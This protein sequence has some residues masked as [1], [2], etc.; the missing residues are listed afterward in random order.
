MDEVYCDIK[1]EINSNCQESKIF[2]EQ[3][4]RK[5]HQYLDSDILKELPDQFHQRFW[6][7]YLAASLLEAGLNLQRSSGRDGSD[8]CIKANDGSKIWVEAVTASLGQG[9][10]AVQETEIGAVRSVPDDQIKLRLLNAFAEK[11]R[12]YRCYR[13]KNWVGSEEP[14]IIAINAAQVPSATRELE[15][16]RIVRSLLP[17]GFQVLHLSRETLEVA[18]TSYEYQGEVV[19]ASGTEI[20]TTSFLNP[21]YSGISAV[22]YSC[23]DVFN[24]P[25]EISKALLLFHNPLSATP[26]PLAFLKNSL[27]DRTRP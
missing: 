26:L 8:I 24:Y 20:E 22:I 12:K 2:V 5:A 17:F 18:G 16:P 3:L 19:K 9:N 25:T 11:S 4:W 6:E 10:D 14:Y 15:I 21:E 13:E 23:V 7:I 27:R 1:N